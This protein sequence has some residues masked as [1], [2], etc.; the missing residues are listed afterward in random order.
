MGGRER[1]GGKEGYVEGGREGGWG[2]GWGD[3]RA[4]EQ[5]SE[6][7]REIASARERETLL[8]TTLHNVAG[9]QVGLLKSSKMPL[10]PAFCREPTVPT[11]TA[12]PPLLS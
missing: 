12:R 6:N 11:P 4:R 8:G 7:E 9:D 3:E 10:S 5:E 2:G 1:G